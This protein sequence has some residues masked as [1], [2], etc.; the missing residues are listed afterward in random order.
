MKCEQHYEKKQEKM[1]HSI[2]QTSS[3]PSNLPRFL[4]QLRQL[5]RQLTEIDQEPQI[6]QQRDHDGKTF[7][8]TYE[9]RSRRSTCCANEDEV[10]MWLEQFH[11]WNTG[12]R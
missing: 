12:G 2:V 3:Q 7:Y 4:H 5:M 9:P 10:R 6:W 11:Y 8:R 1:I